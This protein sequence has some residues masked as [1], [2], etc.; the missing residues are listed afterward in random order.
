MPPSRGLVYDTG[1]LVAAER[2]DRRTWLLHQRA[3]AAGVVPVVPVVVLVQVWRGGPQH[4]MSRLLRGCA[5][6]GIDEQICR[7]AGV[8]CA[9]TGT[10]DAVDALVVVIAARL[11]AAVAT[12][13]PD[14]IRRLAEAAGHQ[15][16]VR[17][18]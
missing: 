16:P 1:V 8:L 3:I 6:G 12:S 2:N 9:K 7:A 13:D 4:Q 18:V 17:P 14:D 5:T 10:S 11:G 15:I